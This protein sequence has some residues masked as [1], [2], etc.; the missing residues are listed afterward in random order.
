MEIMVAN[1]SKLNE[2]KRTKHFNRFIGIEI[3]TLRFEGLHLLN[4]CYLHKF[5]RKLK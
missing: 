5:Y 3:R 1:L 4:R 2:R